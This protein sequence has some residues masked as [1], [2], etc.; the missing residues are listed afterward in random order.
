MT[1][2][3]TFVATSPNRE[4]VFTAVL[5][6]WKAA[7]YGPSIRDLAKMTHLS[8]ATV[9]WHVQI[10]IDQGRLVRHNGVARSLRVAP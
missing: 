7:G 8:V 1:C 9:Q 3:T 5:C 2:S 10:L 6:W 4:R